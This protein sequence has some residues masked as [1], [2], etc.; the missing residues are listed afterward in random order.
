MSVSVLQT[1]LTV[2]PSCSSIFGTFYIMYNYMVITP[3]ACARGKAIAIVCRR[4]VVVTRSRDLGIRATHKYNESIEFGKKK[5]KKI[6][7]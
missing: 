6:T 5:K 1:I 3:R 4:V 7:H 2:P